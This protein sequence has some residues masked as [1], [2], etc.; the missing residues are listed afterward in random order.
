MFV[1]PLKESLS[2]YFRG[3]TEIQAMCETPP[4]NHHSSQINISLNR[5]L[6]M[7]KSK[8]LALLALAFSCLIN[9]IFAESLF[10]QDVKIQIMEADGDVSESLALQY[11]DQT[12]ASLT[13]DYTQKLKVVRGV[14]LDTQRDIET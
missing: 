2:L 8:L 9:P 5:H 3:N 1:C 7:Q 11:K 6:T 10:P 4:M 12:D 14:F 13:L